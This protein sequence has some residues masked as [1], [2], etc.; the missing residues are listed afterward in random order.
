[1]A[2]IETEAAPTTVD[3]VA[4]RRLLD[5]EHRLARE[6]TRAVLAGQE[7]AKGSEPLPTEEYRAQ[8][9][10]W[11]R[12][13]AST[14]GPAL[15]FPEE[16]GGLGRVGDAIACFETLAHSD[17]SLL[18]KCGVQFGLFG[19][20]VHHLGTRRHHERYLAEIASFELPGAFA[21]SESGHGSD[22][23]RVRTTATYDPDS[24]EF[25]LETPSDEDRKDYIGNAARDGRLAA[26][27]CQ[28]VVG[29]TPRG[30]HCLLVPIRDQDGEVAENVRIE[31]CGHKLGL[32]GVDNGRI[33]FDRVRVPRENLLDR[34]AQVSAEGE[35]TSPIESENRRFFTMLGTLIQG[36]I[37]V[38]GA[39]ISAAK[40]ALTIAIR[41][42]LR[43]RQF[44][45]PD[46]ELELPLLDYR[47]H[48]R[49]LLPALAR[50]Y[51]LHFAQQGV[52]AELD[53]IF[54]ADDGSAEQSEAEQ[55]ARRELETRA[56]GLKALAT[57]HA[58]ETIQGCREACGGAGYL[59]VN[60][61][62]ALAADTD[63]FTTFEG[64]NT[65][66]LQL[67]AKSLLTGYRDEFGELGPVATA[68]FVAGQVWETVVERTAAREII[69]RLTDDL[70]PGRE[71]EEDLVDREY[72]LGL[73]RWR[74]EHILSAAAR[75][76]KRGIDDGGDPFEVFNDCQDHVLA[77]ARAH[78][79]RELLEAFADAVDRCEDPELKLVLGRLCDLHALAEIERDR[80]WF[81]EHGRISS[82][83]AKAV[84]R[85]VN[86][87]C[88]GLRE[89]AAELV[90][91]FG[92][93]DQLLAAPIG[94]PGGEA[95]RTAMAEV[96]DG[97][98][99]VRMVLREAGNETGA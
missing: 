57:W 24:Q 4:L 8:V 93:P 80:A 85:S 31:D 52:V 38:G 43:R 64:D 27:F 11:T 84:T 3:A 76:L 59:S 65:I 96:G 73:F 7:F 9:T 49:R 63:V 37:S 46:S 67:V 47:V 55:Q 70:V 19:G 20:A 5:G 28:L 18:V 36:R 12:T 42:A 97:V 39:S 34:Y 15:L 71:R 69:Q 23:Q 33:W 6:H 30:V 89:H 77:T 35:Y 58:A 74:E 54:G 44:G 90:D 87:L 82:T 79:E 21:M 26:V 95:S 56:A 14:G 22:V 83:R 40:S 16:F 99:D 60:R 51:A 88:A 94:L 78:T 68:G 13:L 66:L 1:M 45:P 62:G 53:R 50:T 25:V 41:H 92:I 2:S 91:A 10:E 61:L 32:N 98:P 48:Q 86:G 72:H 29:D 81:Q 17:L 75:R